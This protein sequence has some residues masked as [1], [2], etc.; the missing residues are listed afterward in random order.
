MD[1]LTGTIAQA[2]E[3]DIGRRW[4]EEEP[5]QPLEKLIAAQQ[6]RYVENIASF[7]PLV[8]PMASIPLKS[9]QLEA[10]WHNGWMD[11]TDTVSIYA[12]I[13]RNRPATY[14]EIGSGNSTMF[15]R[16]AI[17]DH[18]IRT[19]IISVDP[20]PRAGIDAMCDEA[21]RK[22]LENTD[23][24][25]WVAALKPGDIV[26]FDG[27]HRCFQNSDVTVFFNEILPAVPAGVLIGIHDIFLPADYAMEW[28]PRF[29]SEQYM[30]ACWLLADA[31]RSLAIELPVYWMTLLPG[32]EEARKSME[33][34]WEKLPKDVVRGGG[35]FWFS[36]K[37][38][39]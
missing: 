13:A 17:S 5:L 38:K 11:A 8:A 26:F 3:L 34:L 33:P 32:A 9:E 39:L 29:Y 27:S 25:P 2:F 19:R 37:E 23:W 28:I 10:H 4:S 1:N 30:L 24:K 6:S 7:I 18:N 36:K 15:A 14:W 21:I 31:G 16:R 12:F 22:R 35:A 20:Q